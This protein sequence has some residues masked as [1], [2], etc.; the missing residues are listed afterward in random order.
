MALDDLDDG[1]E[2]SYYWRLL[3]PWWRRIAKVVAAI[4]VATFLFTQ[5]GLYHYY[6]AEA[7]LRP[8]SQEPQSTVNLGGLLGSIA[9]LSGGG[10]LSSLFGNGTP[11]D[12]SEHMTI[13]SSY[14]FTMEIVDRFNLAS[15]LRPKTRLHELEA[16]L[17]MHPYS[18]YSQYRA[19]ERRFDYD[20]DTKLCN[21]ELYFEDTD[22]DFARKVL[23]GYV[24]GL[25]N[26]LRDQ[27]V[28]EA[29]LSIK[30]M[31][32]Q[33]RNTS[34]ALLINQLDQLIAQE[35]QQEV[36]A[37]AQSD[38][39]FVVEEPPYV[40]GGIYTP[41]PLLDAVIA[42]IATCF[43]AVIWIVVRDRVTRSHRDTQRL[44]AL[45][46]EPRETASAREE[47]GLGLRE[48]VRSRAQTG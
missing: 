33:L 42:A 11:T 8:A 47:D 21:V 2:L 38:F 39:A 16:R 15:R 29:S 35:I 43:L 23:Q 20:Y 13:V 46:L 17:G 4:T 18:R 7:L 32:A 1:V 3:R 26:R 24:D 41:W 27:A 9:G 6:R 28:L 22:P 31:E 40:A 25:R 45:G 37:E 10:A 14:K 30:A 12:A 36:T 44:V 5:F 34:D 19:M 48:P